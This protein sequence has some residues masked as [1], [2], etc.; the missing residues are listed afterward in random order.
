MGQ[1]PD[2][3][4]HA[5]V[6]KW[7][8]EKSENKRGLSSSLCLPLSTP[9]PA[10]SAL[11]VFSGIISH[12]FNNRQPGHFSSFLP[13]LSQIASWRCH[14][15]GHSPA[16]SCCLVVV[17][18]SPPPLFLSWSDVCSCHSTIPPVKSVPQRTLADVSACMAPSQPPESWGFRYATVSEGQT[19]TAVKL[20]SRTY[21]IETLKARGDVGG[22]LEMLNP[23]CKPTDDWAS[24]AGRH[25]LMETWGTSPDCRVWVERRLVF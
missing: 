19:H 2:V 17:S 25:S 9:A 8:K 21:R 12:R 3:C 15:Q 16:H 14:Q 18:F 6:R 13:G 7:D 20:C 22:F 24:F 1:T 4:V 10:H 23:N 11:R 5:C